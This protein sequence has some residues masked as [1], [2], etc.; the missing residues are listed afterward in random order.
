MASD[1]GE[2]GKASYFLA[3]CV[4][5]RDTTKATT[6]TNDN[7]SCII[8]NTF[9]ER[10]STVASELFRVPKNSNLKFCELS[11]QDFYRPG[12]FQIIGCMKHVSEIIAASLGAIYELS[13]IGFTTALKLRFLKK[14]RHQFDIRSETGEA[15]KSE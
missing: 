6:V 5:V 12:I 4:T 11:Q 15:T 8:N 2:M 1:K 7:R 3:L 9:V 14:G 10:H 13:V